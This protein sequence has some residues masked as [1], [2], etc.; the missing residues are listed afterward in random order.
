MI[1]STAL[2]IVYLAAIILWIILGMGYI[3]GV[4]DLISK[5]LKATR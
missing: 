3:F 4:I 1:K 2:R 5:T